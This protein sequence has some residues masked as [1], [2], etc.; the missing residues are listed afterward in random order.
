MKEQDKGRFRAN[1]SWFNQFFDEINQLYKVIFDLLPEE[2]ISKD[3]T[4][5]SGNYYFPRFKIAPSIPTYYA[6][7]LEG[8]KFALQAVAVIDTTL[9]THNGPFIIE[10]SLIILI[11][12]QGEKY[13][14]LSEFALKVIKNQEVE[15]T[16]TVDGVFWGKIK[17]KFPAQFFAFQV[18]YDY[19]TDSNLHIPVK[20]YI[21]DPIVENMER[22]F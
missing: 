20:K 4:L 21:I 6:L 10:P 22:G 8:R 19:F 14:W 11:H 15:F 13:G 1:I 5:S 16:E 7:M 18:Q 17:A 2:F 3:Y 9:F 12:T